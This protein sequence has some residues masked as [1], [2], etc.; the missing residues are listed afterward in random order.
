MANPADQST[1]LLMPDIAA[2]QLMLQ[3]RQSMADMLRQQSM[4][5]LKGAMVGAQ[6]IAP[7]WSQELNG[8]AQA[9]LA[10]KS[11]DDIDAKSLDLAE[12]RSKRMGAEFGDGSSDP[13]VASSA[14]LSQ[15]A[16]Q[17]PSLADASG[18]ATNAGGIGPTNDNAKRMGQILAQ[19]NGTAPKGGGLTLPGMTPRM[20]MLAYSL[21]P[22]AYMGSFIKQY[23]TPDSVKTNNYY[24]LSRGEVAGNMR[25]EAAVK[26]TMPVRQGQTLT[27]PN[28][29]TGLMEPYFTAP[30]QDNGTSTNWVDGKPVVSEIQGAAGVKQN[31]ALAGKL[32]ITLGTLGQGVEDGTNKPTYYLGLPPGTVDGSKQGP[33]SES[34][35][36]GTGLDI[37]KMSSKQIQDLASSDPQAFAAGVQRFKQSQQAPASTIRPATLPGQSKYMDELGGAAAKR[38]T[39]LVTQAQ[40]SP[41]RVNVLDNI[42]K[43]SQDGVQSG[44]TQEWKNKVKGIAADSFGIKSWKDDV[45][46]FDEMSKFMA[47]N[48]NR[49][50]QAAG[51]SG[52][53]A[54]LDAQIKANV[55]NGLFP[56]AV[57]ALANWSKAGELALQAKA[58]AA[59]RMNLDTPQAQTQF[60]NN[61]RQSLDPRVFQIK[62]MPPSKAATYLDDLKK[63]QPQEYAKI[64][65]SATRLKELGGL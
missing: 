36:P 25:A 9:L 43:L 51:G 46:G 35:V 3:R 30:D 57:Q 63:N 41:T 38:S 22:N 5:P 27:R 54:Q 34:S 20:A 52:T 55:R 49:A 13:S 62:T 65:A 47:Q 42:I 10:S 12:Q 18:T 60:E 61:W 32:G 24:G 19:G 58:T 59:G 17:Q 15:G 40:D 45:S 26:G 14:A 1:N 53:D 33:I 4:T 11:Q 16:I 7:S 64:Q 31:M 29:V 56:N 6:Y 37:S 48:A 21:D 28:P 8:M 23:D 44:P 39:D 50:W 2:Q